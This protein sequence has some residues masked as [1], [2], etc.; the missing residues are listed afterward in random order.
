VGVFDLDEGGRIG[1]LSK[2]TEDARCLS[3]NL[4]I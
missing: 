3:K 1:E 4:G 2:K